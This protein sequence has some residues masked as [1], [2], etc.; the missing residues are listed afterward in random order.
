MALAGSSAAVVW[1]LIS[2]SGAL[3]VDD[4]LGVESQHMSQ[5]RTADAGGFHA[6]SSQENTG[7]V[8]TR[9]I[10][11]EWN[12]R[13]RRKKMREKNDEA[14]DDGKNAHSLYQKFSRGSILDLVSEARVPASG[15]VAEDSESSAGVRPQKKDKDTEA[16]RFCPITL[17]SSFETCKKKNSYGPCQFTSE[18]CPDGGIKSSITA[19]CL[20]HELKVTSKTVDC[21]NQKKEEK[22]GKETNLDEVSADSQ[23]TSKTTSKTTSNRTSTTSSTTISKT[24]RAADSEKAEST[25]TEKSL[26]SKGKELDNGKNAELSDTDEDYEEDDYKED[27]ASKARKASKARPKKNKRKK[28]GKGTTTSKP[29][30]KKEKKNVDRNKKGEEELAEEKVDSETLENNDPEADG[31]MDSKVDG[32]NDSN[33]DKK[34]DSKADGK[35]ALTADGKR[36]SKAHGKKDSD[37]AALNKEAEKKVEHE[38]GSMAGGGE[39]VAKAKP[40]IKILKISGK[41]NRT[42]RAPAFT[43]G[44]AQ[45]FNKSRFR[46]STFSFPRSGLGV[47]GQ[48]NPYSK[49]MTI[50]QLAEEKEVRETTAELRRAEAEERRRFGGGLSPSLKMSGFQ[51]QDLSYLSPWE[52]QEVRET[53][54]EAEW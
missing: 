23:A 6:S 16:T 27:T 5:A 24:A 44:P 25:T 19:N 49:A 21:E 39:F 42:S 7:F 17:E 29:Q 30:M 33:A 47:L 12:L 14:D 22:E 26:K 37:G 3:R 40:S 20:N 28:N 31:K 46:T 38:S 43:D 10:I 36:D 48:H 35:K 52:A 34:K 18:L 11:P 32:K 50:E 9:G 15:D 54:R 45:P 8:L 53:A 41:I 2:I 4:A 13:N 51:E 1:T